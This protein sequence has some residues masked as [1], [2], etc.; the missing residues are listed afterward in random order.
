VKICLINGSLRGEKAS[1]LFFLQ[2][3]ECL[4]GAG[5]GMELVVVNTRARGGYPSSTLSVVNGAD[6]VV[7]GFPLFVYSLPGAL[8]RL[9]EDWHQRRRAT[10][11]GDQDL[12]VYAI[13]NCGFALPEINGEAIRV[14]MNFCRRLGLRWRFAASIG[15]GPVV[16]MTSG[17]PLLNRGLGRALSEIAADIRAPGTGKRDTILVRPIIPKSVGIAIRRALEM[18]NSRH[19]KKTTKAA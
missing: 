14:L 5:A 6:A 16:V 1:S 3:L 12:R 17:I 19:R 7:I 2:K 13:V 10:A 4:L 11:P 9:L 18:K 8:T 15:C